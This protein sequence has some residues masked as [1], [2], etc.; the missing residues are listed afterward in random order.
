MS[1]RVADLI[2]HEDKLKVIP[3]SIQW[4]EGVADLIP[5]EDRQVEGHIQMNQQSGR[6]CG[7]DPA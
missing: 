1:E 4:S 2:P 5:H 7:F 3:P 6:G